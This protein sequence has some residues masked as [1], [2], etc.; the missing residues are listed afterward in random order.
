[1]LRNKRSRYSMPSRTNSTSSRIS[2][3]RPA[4]RTNKGNQ[5]KTGLNKIARCWVHRTDKPAQP[6]A[7]AQRGELGVFVIESAGPGV[8]VS[9]VAPGSAADAAGLEAGD[10]LMV[11]NGQAVD[12]PQEVIRLIRAIAA[13]EHGEPANLARR[14]GTGACRYV[15]TDAGAR[16]LPKQLPR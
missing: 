11:I 5:V 9:R 3:M 12:Q 8:R 15:A 4:R 1:M 13:G 7:E 16:E 14:P 10:V 2:L 6:G